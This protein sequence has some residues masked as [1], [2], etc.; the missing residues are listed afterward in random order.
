MPKISVDKLE[1]GMK[2]AKPVLAK[3]GMIMLGEGTELSAAWIER[4]Q[5]MEI[6]SVFIEGPTIQAVPKEEA[7]AALQERFAK[8][9]DKPYMNLIKKVV[10]KH[11]EGLYE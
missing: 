3:S 9:E 5:D 7:L 8:V 6:T 11:I 1:P 2:L 10:E 4:I